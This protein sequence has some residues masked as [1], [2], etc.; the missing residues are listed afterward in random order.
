MKVTLVPH[1]LLSRDWGI[2]EKGQVTQGKTRND[3]T[4]VTPMQV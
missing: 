2:M 3:F 4:L 1:L